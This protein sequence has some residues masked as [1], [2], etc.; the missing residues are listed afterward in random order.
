LASGHA[1]GAVKIGSDIEILFFAMS[2][3]VLNSSANKNAS[4]PFII[5]LKAMRSD[6]SVLC[7]EETYSP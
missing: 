3:S 2:S 6:L 1:G 5:N 4:S 7:L